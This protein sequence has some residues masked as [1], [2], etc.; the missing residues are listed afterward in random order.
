MSR[1][2]P[3]EER[4]LKSRK[5]LA[6][7]AV[8]TDAVVAAFRDENDDALPR[9]VLAAL[10]RIDHGSQAATQKAQPDANHWLASSFYLKPDLLSAASLRASRVIDGAS[11][12]GVSIGMPR[13]AN[14]FPEVTPLGLDLF[15]KASLQNSRK[16]GPPLG[17]V[18]ALFDSPAV[19]TV[20]AE[21][22]SAATL[23]DALL[24]SLVP[25]AKSHLTLF[26]QQKKI[27]LTDIES[28][29]VELS[30]ALSGLW[31]GNLPKSLPLTSVGTRRDLLA[32]ESFHGLLHAAVRNSAGGKDKVDEWPPLITAY[33]PGGQ[34][35]LSAQ[36]A[37]GVPLAIC[38]LASTWLRTGWRNLQPNRKDAFLA[39]FSA[40]VAGCAH[41]Q[42]GWVQAT[43]NRTI[44]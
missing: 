38:A 4:V 15:Y 16:G 39:D 43:L 28:E 29:L 12:L 6:Q 44:A 23:S 25:F 18:D 11:G 13:R 27:T 20:L 8:I 31:S 17:G 14:D 21:R 30:E 37:S 34:A 32:C 7:H 24:L 26:T 10:A 35:R 2:G 36:G 33:L 3:I 9:S 22:A 19:L 41:E 40:L 1:V 5:L 42:A